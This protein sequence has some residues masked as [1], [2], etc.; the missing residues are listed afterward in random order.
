MSLWICIGIASLL[1]AVK[2][3]DT[4][5]GALTASDIVHATP[6]QVWQAFTTREGQESWQVSHADIDL[7]VGGLM[8]THYNPEGRIGDEDTINNE[9]LSYDPERMLSFRIVRPPKQFAMNWR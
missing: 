9:V 6:T 3:H 2:P 4:A 8:R 5:P 7:R 1:V